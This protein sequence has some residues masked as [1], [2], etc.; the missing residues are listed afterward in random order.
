MRL[1]RFTPRRLAVAAIIMV[2][3]LASTAIHR[4]F[5]GA[6]G[7]KELA[8]QADRLGVKRR[9]ILR[10]AGERIAWNPSS[11]ALATTSGESTADTATI[12]DAST[13]RRQ[14]VLS[15]HREIYGLDWSKDGKLVAT[16]SWD[17]TAAV[18][19]A[20]TG[21]RLLTLR[22][23]P[24]MIFDVAF[25]ADGKTLATCA[26]D[27]LVILWDTGSGQ[28]RSKLRGHSS[29]VVDVGWSPDGKTLAS[30]S[31]DSTLIWDLTADKPRHALDGSTPRWSPD[32]KTLSTVVNGD[33]ILWDPDTG[34]MRGKLPGTVNGVYCLAWSP[35]GTMLATGSA[36]NG[37]FWRG[38]IPDA[39]LDPPATA[40]I[41]D[42]KT[43][44]VRHVLTGHRHHIASIAWRPDGRFLATGSWD[45]SVIIWAVGSGKRAAT[46]VE[47]IDEVVDAVAW[48]T[49][50]KVLATTFG[51]FHMSTILWETT[52]NKALVK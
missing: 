8:D 5:A 6:G 34:K 48:S 46:L 18:W 38:L 9:T 27:N 7:A 16:G 40:T 19:D 43:F 32:G 1:P 4:F 26:G 20:A 21:N 11:S 47:G 37:G 14:A 17:R 35:D 2:V 29:R 51:S 10:N 50:G 31:D 22:G 45:K 41:W 28:V 49:D 15:G 25:S 42:A 23:H 13:G 44:K 39:M 12:W 36:D 33:L 24:G 3:A 52:T 30:G